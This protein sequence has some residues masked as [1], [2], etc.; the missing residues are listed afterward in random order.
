MLQRSCLD[1]QTRTGARADQ[2]HWSSRI[3]DPVDL[4]VEK[5]RGAD[6]AAT[7]AVTV[8][9]TLAAAAVAVLPPTP[10]PPPQRQ[11]KLQ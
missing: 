2:E 11:L 3:Q 6:W 7:A 9:A 10:P 8:A 4:Q 1:I 5:L